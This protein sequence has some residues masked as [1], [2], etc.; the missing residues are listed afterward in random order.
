M[1]I[2]EIDKVPRDFPNDLLHEL[3]QMNFRV[4][5]TGEVI[6]PE[7]RVSPILFITSNSER[8]LPEPFLRRCVYHHIE[9]DDAIV[10]KAVEKCKDQYHTLRKGLLELAIRCFLA[11]RDRNLRKL[12]ATGELLVW[13][14]VITLA[15]QSEKRVEIEK[16]LKDDNLGR[17]PYLGVLLKDH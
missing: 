2:D 15:V 3:D 4:I 11:L 16:N 12:P 9:F 5:E 7:R 1:A 6:R 8:R 17:L 14:R 10:L 13:L